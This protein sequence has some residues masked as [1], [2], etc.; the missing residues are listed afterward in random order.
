MTPCGMK[1][2]TLAGSVGGGAQTPGFVGH[3]KFYMGSPQ[4]HQRRRRRRPAGLDAQEAQRGAGR[5]AIDANAEKQPATPTSS[6][7]SPPR[8]NGTEE[9]EILAYLTEVGHP[10][11]EM[12]P[13]F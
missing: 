11:L 2:S 13:M 12:D 6:T 1:F 3:S 10:A 7:R 9:D 4:V 8:S 5:P